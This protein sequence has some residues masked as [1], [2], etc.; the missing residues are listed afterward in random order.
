MLPSKTYRI[1]RGFG[2]KWETVA[3]FAILVSDC[4]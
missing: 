4:K 3:T 2:T 1:E